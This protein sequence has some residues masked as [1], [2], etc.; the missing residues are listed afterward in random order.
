MTP[1]QKFRYNNPDYKKN[2]IF[3]K[4]DL[5]KFKTNYVYIT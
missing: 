1:Y 2:M 4:T 3:V 5:D